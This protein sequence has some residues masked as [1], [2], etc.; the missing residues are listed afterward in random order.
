LRLKVLES[1]SSCSEDG[2]LFQAGILEVI[3]IW[4]QI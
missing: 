2:R 4:I 3:C 1:V